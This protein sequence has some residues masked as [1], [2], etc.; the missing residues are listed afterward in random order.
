VYLQSNS[1][2]KL[3]LSEVRFGGTVY[4]YNS[5]S[6]VTGSYQLLTR[7]PDTILSATTAEVQ[8]GQQVSIILQLDENIK[9]GRDTQ[10]KLTTANGAVFVGTVI[11]GQTSG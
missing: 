8:P 5:T 2:G 1:V 9:P 11:A 4:G 10:M 7:G 6:P 3:T